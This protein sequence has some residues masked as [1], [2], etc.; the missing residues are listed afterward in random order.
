MSAAEASPI[1]IPSEDE[2]FE[3][4]E[5]LQYIKEE[6]APPITIDETEDQDDIIFVSTCPP[7]PPT[8]SWDDSLGIADVHLGTFDHLGL[9]TSPAPSCSQMG[10]MHHILNDSLPPSVAVG[11]AD[12]PSLGSVFPPLDTAKMTGSHLSAAGLLSS[13]GVPNLTGVQ[14]HP[15]TSGSLPAT[16]L[17]SDIKSQ[18]GT[19]PADRVAVEDK[20]SRSSGPSTK[21]V[22]LSCLTS[23]TLTPVALTPMDKV[24]LRKTIKPGRKTLPQYF[25][26]SDSDSDSSSGDTTDGESGADSGGVAGGGKNSSCPASKTLLWRLTGATSMTKG[27]AGSRSA[28]GSGGI[29]GSSPAVGQS[30]TSQGVSAASSPTASNIP[31]PSSSSPS[32]SARYAVTLASWLEQALPAC[33]SSVAQRSPTVQTAAHNVFKLTTANH[34]SSS[35]IQAPDH[36]GATST[37]S[38][39]FSSTDSMQ[40][41]PRI[42]ALAPSHS[43]TSSRIIAVASSSTDSVSRVNTLSSLPSDS[44][45]ATS[46]GSQGGVAMVAHSLDSSVRVTVQQALVQSSTASSS[47]CSTHTHT[48]LNGRQTANCSGQQQAGSSAGSDCGMMGVCMQPKDTQDFF[49]KLLGDCNSILSCNSVP[50]SFGSSPSV[51]S[52][53]STLF[54]PAGV[55][56]PAS[57]TGTVVGGGT[58]KRPNPSSLSSLNNSSLPPRKRVRP[59]LMH[60]ASFSTSTAPPSALPPTPPVTSQPSASS[61]QDS[62]SASKPPNPL[63]RSC[64]YPATTQLADSSR[65]QWGVSGMSTSGAAKGAGSV[66][67]PSTSGVAMAMGAECSKCQMR[68]GERTGEGGECKLSLCPHSH[69]ACGRCLMV[70]ARRVLSGKQK[71]TLQ[72]I[73]VA[74]STFYTIN[75]LRN[76]LPSLIVEILQE[77]LDQEFVEIIDNM[78]TH[79]ADAHSADR[80]PSH[81]HKAQRT[82]SHQSKRCRTFLRSSSETDEDSFYDNDDSG[83]EMPAECF[84]GDCD[85]FSDGDPFCGEVGPGGRQGEKRE[86]FPDH[87]SRMDNSKNLVEV[88]GVPLEPDSDEYIN[89]A[90]RFHEHLFFP[91]TDITRI[92]R[93]QNPYLWKSYALKKEQMIQ[94]NDKMAVK[95]YQLF[96]GTKGN[97]VEAI[98]RRGFDWRFCGK[99]GTAYGHGC[100][101]A[102]D[103]YYSNTYTDR[104]NAPATGAEFLKSIMQLTA[105]QTTPPSP[106]SIAPTPQPPPHSGSQR[107]GPPP[108]LIQGGSSLSAAS[109]GGLKKLLPLLKSGLHTKQTLLAQLLKKRALLQ[110][111]ANSSVSS[112]QSSAQLS[113]Q[114]S[115]HSSAH[116]P[117]QL[118]AAQCQAVTGQPGGGLPQHQI[119]VSASAIPQQAHSQPHSQSHS[120]SHSQH[121]SQLH[122][123]SQPPPQLH[124]YGHYSLLPGSKRAR[125]TQAASAQPVPLGHHS[126]PAP[127]S[128]HHGQ[129]QPLPPMGTSPP[130]HKPHPGFSSG[131]K[132]GFFSPPGK[133]YSGRAPAGYSAGSQPPGGKAVLA[134]LVPGQP[135]G[136]VMGNQAGGGGLMVPMYGTGLSTS[137]SSAVALLTASSVSSAPNNSGY[138]LLAAPAPAPSLGPLHPPLL[139]QPPHLPPKTSSWHSALTSSPSG[140]AL[141]LRKSGASS[142]RYM[143]LAKVLTGRATG[144]QPEF[145]RPPPLDLLDPLGRCYDSCVDNIYHPRIWVVF[146][147]T[148]AYP[149][150]VI[151]YIVNDD[152]YR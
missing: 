18:S 29:P 98:C 50:S 67:L 3:D 52:A 122:S 27:Q 102:G 113:A 112:L 142:P 14:L 132:P 87:W 114:P 100:Y 42:N 60:S 70:Q 7:P 32:S 44:V 25:S 6:K 95:E 152:L 117:A 105:T 4:G 41:S 45:G 99:H 35:V 13:A 62:G 57:N 81:R 15:V 140:Q 151:E 136:A 51:S 127:Q 89:V 61:G 36:V 120:Q 77:R 86:D 148:Q 138:L 2:D 26:D 85:E 38:M 49:D 134:Q 34:S 76:S 55:K 109:R 121:L 78:M 93:I 8:P 96:H 107:S 16:S 54:G 68:E 71:E 23:A 92:V 74:C 129:L 146:D 90:V 80:L 46:S 28:S 119:A 108:L 126:N 73:V 123:L 22:T 144:G 118:S 143:F 31:P 47:L 137:L 130:G 66:S 141:D 75:E 63:A 83:S 147:S 79:K 72:C 40:S 56:P 103:S 139:T 12:L 24:S 115:A 91:A 5:E 11:A 88:V 33:P 110:T 149:E 124:Q 101:F 69:A 39:S 94:E 48:Q 128:L 21:L 43:D 106:S 20:R 59:P 64:S 9:G 53:A 84:D 65:S 82:K 135:G 104:T 1:L 37:A 133:K 17:P 125:P 19:T 145:R 150:Y 116:L 97:T 30:A 58:V 111:A 10:D 131:G